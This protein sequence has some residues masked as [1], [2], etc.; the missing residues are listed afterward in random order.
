[1]REHRGQESS[2]EPR[3]GEVGLDEAGNARRKV[4]KAGVAVGV[5]V[6]A[7]SGPTISSI[8]GTPAYAAVCTQPAVQQFDLADDT[9]VDLRDLCDIGGNQYV[10]WQDNFGTPTLPAG[11][12]IDLSQFSGECS[13]IPRPISWTS[14]S[15]VKCQ[16]Q[17]TVYNQNG[18]P[19]IGVSPSSSVSFTVNEGPGDSGT[20]P[21]PPPTATR[22]CFSR[23]TPANEY[24][25][26]C[27]GIASNARYSISLVC[28]DKN[29]QCFPLGF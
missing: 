23:A 11:Y 4:L 7:W 15:D 3:H 2:D 29:A 26:S 9:N 13:N 27:Y 20:A 1:M 18:S 16:L 12:T 14:P 28:V 8:G 22:Q 17:V 25:S 5:G 6:V 24:D 21:I 10:W 19:I